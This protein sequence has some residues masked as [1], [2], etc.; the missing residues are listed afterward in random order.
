MCGLSISAPLFCGLNLKQLRL[1]FEHIAFRLVSQ[2]VGVLVQARYGLALKLLG[3]FVCTGWTIQ[4]RLK[5]SRFNCTLWLN[6]AITPCFNC[7]QRKKQ[8]QATL[9]RYPTFRWFLSNSKLVSSYYL[10]N[11]T[12]RAVTD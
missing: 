9:I 1:R 10:Y 8:S 4:S 11:E 5:I 6:N 3:H 7:H 2:C 12:E